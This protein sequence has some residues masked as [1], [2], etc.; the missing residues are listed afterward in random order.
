M[1]GGRSDAPAATAAMAAIAADVAEESRIP[2]ALLGGYLRALAAV[3]GTERR[4]ARRELDACRDRGMEAATAGVPL[5]AVVDAYLT[6]TWRAWDQLPAARAA[7]DV[8]VL[9]SVV[10]TVLRAADDTVAA[11]ADGYQQG[12]R[13]VIRTEEGLRREFI[14]DLLTG[15]GDY[16]VLSVP[17]GI[18][19]D[20]SGRRT[21]PG[22][23]SSCML[24]I[25]S[26]AL[27]EWPPGAERQPGP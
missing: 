25:A 24:C 17:L 12:Q 26:Q 19:L 14:D 2:V 20:P 13:D 16:V 18:T 9:R 8:A 15:R 21:A 6:A 22:R 23:I 10:R 11:L 7:V 4:L 27:D 3:A 5:R 1:G